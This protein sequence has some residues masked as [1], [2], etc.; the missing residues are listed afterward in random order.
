MSWRMAAGASVF[1]C[2]T[3][4]AA[5]ASAINHA[6]FVAHIVEVGNWSATAAPRAT[7]PGLVIAL[8]FV[9]AA[10][11]GQTLL[12]RDLE[13]L[14]RTPNVARRTAY[15]RSAVVPTDVRTASPP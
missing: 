13:S 4:A 10:S 8:P 11:A 2:V 1:L 12:H 14:S 7:A 6:G 9:A 5:L 15:R 3:L